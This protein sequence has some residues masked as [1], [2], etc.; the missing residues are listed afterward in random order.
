ME[1]IQQAVIFNEKDQFLVL[2]YSGVYGP[3]V[4]GKWTFPS[5][6]LEKNENY[7]DALKREVK[8]ETGLDIDIVYQF[9]SS[10][11][12]TVDGEK[13]LTVV[14]LCR[15][16]G[17]KIKLCKE[18]TDYKWVSLKDL[19]KMKLINPVMIEIAEKAMMLLGGGSEA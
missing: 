8:E 17:K 2:K 4:K 15:P 9:F 1:A 12:T 16:K 14:Y 18:H 6:R 19:K 11:I 3:K 10:I 13:V 5:G 7:E